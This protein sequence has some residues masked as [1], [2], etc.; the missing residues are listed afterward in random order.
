MRVAGTSRTRFFAYRDLDD[1]RVTGGDLELLRRGNV[2]VR[3]QLH[4]ADAVRRDAVCDRIRRHIDAREGGK[5]AV[6]AQLVASASREQLARVASGGADYRAA[7]LSREALW[8]LIEGP[9]VDAASRRATAEAL[10]KTSDEGE[11]ARLR[12]A[13]EH[14]A[15]PQVRVALERLAETDTLEAPGASPKR[16]TS[17]LA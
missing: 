4:G 2:V 7:S 8:A 5:D 17:T 9:A 10:A 6:A 16:A 11:R 1:V 14:C 13:A 3:L 12:V 15:D